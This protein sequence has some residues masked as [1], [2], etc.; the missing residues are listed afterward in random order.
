MRLDH[1]L[2]ART[3]IGPLLKVVTAALETDGIAAVC[4]A[5]VPRDAEVPAGPAVRV[6]THALPFISMFTPPLIK[7]APF[8]AP[9]SREALPEFMRL[10]HDQALAV[11]GD[12]TFIDV[13]GHAPGVFAWYRDFYQRLFRGGGVPVAMKELARYRL[14]TLHGC[15]FCNKGNRLDAMS[16]GL[17]EAQIAAIDDL[18]ALCWS[19]AERAVIRLAEQM[20]LGKSDGVVSAELHAELVRHFDNEQILELGVTMAVLTGMAKF[21]FAF[22]L[23]E[24]EG[25]C[26]FGR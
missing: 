7:P 22:D 18:E 5:P 14:S 2:P 26:Q 11:R 9:L 17:S 1:R 23:V 19:D 16:A 24:R 3:L 8:I 4:Q 15:A 13:M 21:L 25:Y 10:A 6:V 20:S 12:S